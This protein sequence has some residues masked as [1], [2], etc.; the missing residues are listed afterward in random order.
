MEETPIFPMTVSENDITT[1]L[2]VREAVNS[3]KQPYRTVVVLFYYEN[4][5]VSKIAQITNTNV[6]AVKSS[7]LVPERCCE[8][9]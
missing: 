3:L 8:K 5:S 9:F 2:T 4:L 7:F 6:V 1:S